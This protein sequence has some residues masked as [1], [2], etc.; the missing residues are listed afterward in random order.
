[1][2]LL[3]KLQISLYFPKRITIMKDKLILF[4]IDSTLLRG[5]IPAHLNSFSFGFKNVYNIEGSIE[6]APFVEGRTDKQIVFEILQKKGLERNQIEKN[7]DR[8]FNSM[9]EYAKINFEKENIQV[10]PG[11][12]DFLKVLKKFKINL[13]ILTGN[14]EEIAKIKLTKANLNQYFEVGGYGNL[15]E[16]RSDLIEIVKNRAYEKLGLKFENENIYLVGDSL[17]DVQC[18]NETGVNI[19]GVATGKTSK[20]DLQNAG[21]NI[22]LSTLEEYDKAID[23]IMGNEK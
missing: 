23:Y 21:A 20:E 8:M 11:V 7:I 2:E 1:M 9:V 19:I 6:D 13:G 10:L 5:K 14:V 12:E 16:R 17:R 4:D 15:S 3:Q 22:V 18:G